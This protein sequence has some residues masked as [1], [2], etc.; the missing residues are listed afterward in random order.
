MR[1]MVATDAPP[2]NGSART[3]ASRSSQTGR[4]T[5]MVVSGTSC[6]PCASGS[7]R[8]SV[9]ARSATMQSSASAASITNRAF[10][11]R[12][13]FVAVTPAPSRAP[14]AASAM[15]TPV[16]ISPRAIRGSHAACWAGLPALRSAI[17]AMT[18]LATNGTG[19]TYRPS[20]SATRAASSISRP[21]PPCASEMSIAGTPRPT[22]P[23]QTSRARDSLRSA[24][25]R[26]RSSGDSP[27]SA[28]ATPSCRMRCSSVIA[29]SIGFSCRRLR[30]GG[31]RLSQLGLARQSEAALG[32]D[33][34]LYLRRAAADDEAQ[35]Q[36]VAAL[37]ATAGAHVWPVTEED[38]ELAERV[39]RER[40]HLVVQ[41]AALQLAVQA[42]D[43]RVLVLNRGRQQTQPVE[44]E[45][46]HAPLQLHQPVAQDRVVDQAA[47]VHAFLPH[48]LDETI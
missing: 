39:D 23:S 1:C 11:V 45:R 10:P 38:A 40:G 34:L 33:V 2:P 16:I 44:L 36:H 12:R 31:S 41:L 37:P 26:T 7:T 27:S 24:A 13:P 17:G 25:C 48:Q 35:I 46:E 5:S 9:P 29:K 43:A 20:I 30:S 3:P 21:S 8:C 28:R 19:A 22:S 6:T 18:Q 32:D 42:G 14:A 15:A 4:V 47:A